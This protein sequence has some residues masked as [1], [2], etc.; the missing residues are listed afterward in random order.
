MCVTKHK[1][2]NFSGSNY[3]LSLVLLQ[4]STSIT[5]NKCKKNAICLLDFRMDSILNCCVKITTADLH[6]LSLK[7][8]ECSSEN[9]APKIPARAGPCLALHYPPAPR[10]VHLWWIFF[11][12]TAMNG[13]LPAELKLR[14][15]T[16]GSVWRICTWILRHGLIPI[17]RWI[18][19]SI[20]MIGTPFDATM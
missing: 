2:H 16:G 10:K 17:P 13:P 6:K 18:N 3:K 14:E 19:P 12:S 7:I 15:N 4:I 11:A 1:C 20:Y 5:L 8:R 9:L